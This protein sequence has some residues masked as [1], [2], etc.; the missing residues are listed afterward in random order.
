V[1]LPLAA[2]EKTLRP[3]IVAFLAVPKRF[4]WLAKVI[5]L[6]VLGGFHIE[7]VGRGGRWKN[8]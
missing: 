7:C 8:M 1:S 2:N 5:Y 4:K 6:L 3:T